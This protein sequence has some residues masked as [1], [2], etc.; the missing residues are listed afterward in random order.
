MQVRKDAKVHIGRV[1]AHLPEG[2]WA[3]EAVLFLA[4]QSHGPVETIA[5]QRSVAL[6]G[7]TFGAAI[8][9]VIS[10]FRLFKNR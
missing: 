3:V 5:D 6:F 7:L 2:V 10:L 4:G 9:L 1:Y 8:G